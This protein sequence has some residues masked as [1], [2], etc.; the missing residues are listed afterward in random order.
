MASSQ[1]PTGLLGDVPVQKIAN[2]ARSTPFYLYDV[3]SM[4][5]AARELTGAYGATKA[6]V[7]YAV[8]ANSAGPVVRAFAEEGC[9]A[10]VVSGAEIDL[11]VQASVL[12]ENIVFSGVAKTD[13]EIQHAITL[14]GV[15]IRSICAE[16]V[17]ELLRIA[18]IAK[19]LSRKAN[20]SIRINPE[21]AEDDLHT[22]KHIATGH[23][24]AKFGIARVD[25][26]AAF[27][28][29][30]NSEHLR[31]VGIAC[32]AGSQFTETAAYLAAADILFA[33][34]LELPEPLRSTLQT[35]DTGGGFGID[36]GEGC[37]VR[38]K[39]FIEAVVQKAKTLGL[40]RYT[41]GCEPGRALVA[42]YGILVA[43]VIQT[44]RTPYDGP[45]RKRWLMVD[46]GMNDLLRPALYQ[47]KHRVAPLGQWSGDDVTMRVVGPVCESSDDF[48]DHVLPEI[49]GSHVVFRDAGAYGFT[50]ASEY[51]GR[52]LP[53]EYFWDGKVVSSLFSDS[54]WGA[55]RLS[56]TPNPL[57]EVGL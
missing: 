56:E 5:R 28:V 53:D 7:F 46:A 37:D 40:D 9:G 6:K 51:N 52:M 24:A 27:R 31:F 36:Y 41:L 21:I 32:H 39:H 22:H 17:E 35:I 23:D 38:P 2:A 29:I 4:R 12:P 15:G 44:K 14:G 50:M 57:A 13:R 45:T 48:G 47:A 16:S 43:R 54:P 26:P 49:P 10:D 20:V 1:V 19:S 11:A 33:I 8:K 25:L 34:A 18:Q 55:R 30:S 42:P 3:A